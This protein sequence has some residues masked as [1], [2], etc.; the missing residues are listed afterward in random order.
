MTLSQ[1]EGYR[2]YEN[3]DNVALRVYQEGSEGY[4]TSTGSSSTTEL[5]PVSGHHVEL[6]LVDLTNI[7][8]NTTSYAYFDMDGYR[9]FSL[10]LETSG[11]LPTDV[12]TVTVEATNQDDGTAAAGCTY[13]DVTSEFFGVASVVD[14]DDFLISDTAT[15]LKYVRVKIVTSNDA[16]GDADLTIYAKRMY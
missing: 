5:D 1:Y 6:T 13:Q 12:L 8:T 4:D 9:Y 14:S 2:Y 15:S 7:S 11:A 10:Q 16:G 3:G